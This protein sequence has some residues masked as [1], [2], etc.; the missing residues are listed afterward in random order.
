VGQ[1]GHRLIKKGGHRLPYKYAPDE[2]RNSMFLLLMKKALILYSNLSIYQSIKN[3]YLFIYV[4]L[5]L[6]LEDHGKVPVKGKTVYLS[7][8]LAI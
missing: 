5:P 4:Y 8:Y 6:I 7:I 3:L 2:I 1:K